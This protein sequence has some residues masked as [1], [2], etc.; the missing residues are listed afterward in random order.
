[1][2]HRWLFMLSQVVELRANAMSKQRGQAMVEFALLAPLAL[3]LVVLGVQFA[4]IGRDAVGLS[5][6][7]YQAT[8]W[9]SSIKPDAQCADVTTY[10]TNMASPTIQAIISQSGIA[11]GDSTKGVNVVMSWTCP[12]TTQCTG[13]RPASTQLRISMTLNVAND[14]FVPNP[15]LGVT[16]P[17][18]LQSAQTAYTNT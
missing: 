9:A 11:C 12:D 14:L 18:T 6:A 15:F 17:Q 7:S 13:V 3:L 2:K 4:I 10:V 16:L 5:Q 8:R 1:M